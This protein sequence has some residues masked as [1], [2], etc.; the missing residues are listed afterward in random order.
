VEA[1]RAAAAS[2]AADE[3]VAKIRT[4]MDGIRFAIEDLQ[5]AKLSDERDVLSLRGE[6]DVLRRNGRSVASDNDGLERE[7]KAGLM[8]LQ[9]LT[10]E[11]MEVEANNSILEQRIKVPRP[12]PF[13]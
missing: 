5:K 4:E 12:E 2:R 9:A 11:T 8:R 13:P 1:Q 3:R 7:R 10:K 6:L